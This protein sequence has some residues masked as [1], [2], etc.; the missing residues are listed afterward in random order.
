VLVPGTDPAEDLKIRFLHRVR[1]DSSGIDVRIEGAAES[2]VRAIQTEI[3]SLL[4]RLE[5]S[6]FRTAAGEFASAP[7]RT[8]EAD[9]GD[10]LPRGTGHRRESQTGHNHNE[11]GDAFAG[12][13]PHREQD[14]DPSGSRSGGIRHRDRLSLWSIARQE[15]TGDP[16]E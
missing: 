2:R 8:R 4:Q 15:A 9:Q 11:H 5:Q 3:P 1:G 12:S 16:P 7:E 6:G 10:L 13:N 14:A